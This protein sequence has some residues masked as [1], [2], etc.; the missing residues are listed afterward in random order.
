ML[1]MRQRVKAMKDGVHVKDLPPGKRLTET[2]RDGCKRSTERDEP[3][4]LK[5]HCMCAWHWFLVLGPQHSKCDQ[6]NVFIFVFTY[7]PYTGKGPAY[8]VAENRFFHWVLMEAN[9]I[10]KK[11]S[12][13]SSGPYLEQGVCLYVYLC[14]W[15]SECV[16]VCQWERESKSERLCMYLWE[17]AELWSKTGRYCPSNDARGDTRDLDRRWLS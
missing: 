12:G 3:A 9:K 5:W 8:Y 7:I 15:V 2:D 10:E 13:I 16:C 14:E 11:L 6:N 1:G 4:C 17:S